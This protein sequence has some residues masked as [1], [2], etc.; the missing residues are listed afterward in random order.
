MLL[1]KITLGMFKS[2][3]QMGF[4]YRLNFSDNKLLKADITTL[5]EDA[6]L[7]FRHYVRT[8]HIQR[9]VSVCIADSITHTNKTGL[10]V[11]N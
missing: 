1:S 2:L 3:K 9:C 4:K 5:K 6:H 8:T 7:E 10:G 11:E